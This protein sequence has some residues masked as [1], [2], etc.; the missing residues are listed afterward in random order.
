MLHVEQCIGQIILE[1]N[2]EIAMNDHT[3]VYLKI[4]HLKDAIPSLVTQLSAC[5]DVVLGHS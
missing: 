3:N 1:N 5:M 2:E 4:L